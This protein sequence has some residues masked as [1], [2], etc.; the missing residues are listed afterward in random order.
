MIC[1]G[2]GDNSEKMLDSVL[3]TTVDDVWSL[4]TITFDP[5]ISSV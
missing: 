4:S 5:F 2:L 1:G 3:I